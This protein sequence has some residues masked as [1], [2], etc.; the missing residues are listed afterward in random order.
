MK[1]NSYISEWKLE[2]KLYCSV[3][4]ISEK[5]WNM[6]QK[7]S[8]VTH[9]YK[10]WKAVE[11]SH[12]T[13]FEN[14]KYIV[15]YCD[16]ELV[17]IVPCYTVRTDMAIFSSDFIKKLLG[18]VRYIIPN[19]LTINILE[20]GSP[21]II[22]TPQ[23]LVSSKIPKNI[24]LKKLNKTLT[25][26]AF[27]QRCIFIMLRDFES[28]HDITQ[29]KLCLKKLRFF[30]VPS[31]PNTFLDINWD[32][33]DKY[34]SSM[35]S[36]YRYK[37]KKYLNKSKLHNISYKLIDDFSDIADE[38]CR[39]WIVVHNNAKELKRELLTPEFYREFSNLMGTDSKVLLF[40]NDGKLCAHA[41]LLKDN[42]TL[43]WMYVGR[44]D[45]TPDYLY[46]YV[47]H[48]IVETAI[49]MKVC[50]LEMGMTTYPIKQDFGAELVSVNVA[51]K[52]TLPFFNLFVGPVYNALH[53][54]NKYITKR[55]FK[56]N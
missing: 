40:Y 9:S 52:M 36:H 45:T 46:F 17:A 14:L 1:H 15:Y 35:R 24:F 29:Y 8:S 5:Q 32:S 56:D 55:V 43:R 34:H 33:I 48:K 54:S 38:L 31:L 41:L 18:I 37:L 20:C 6:L 12:F 22:N 39:Q 27:R 51:L 42:D 3:D 26:L 10:F 28:N 7:N 11:K 2:Y 50:R 44:D 13:T 25:K 16:K 30:W 47:I 53:N 19:F 4:E 49:L 23:F 21:V